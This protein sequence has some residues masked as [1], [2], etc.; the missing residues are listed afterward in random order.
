MVLPLLRCSGDAVIT[1]TQNFD[2]QL[3]VFLK[4]KKKKKTNL[5]LKTD[6][7][8]GRI[9][10]ARNC[11][12]FFFVFSYLCQAIKPGKELV[13]YL[14]QLVGGKSGGDGRESDNV[15]KEDAVK[16]E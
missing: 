9:S 2:S 10:S 5:E 6:L 7:C 1:I 13:E 8:Y 11:I 14:D 3:M 15:S 12:C 16:R 4:K